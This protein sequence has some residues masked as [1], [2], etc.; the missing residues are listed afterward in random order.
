MTLT[1]KGK[2]KTSGEEKPSG[3]GTP[4]PVR[5]YKC[6][7]LGYRANECQGSKTKCFKCGKTNHKV[8]DCRSNGI[9]CYNYGE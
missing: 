4:A 5:C 6:D 2:Q 1:D 7:V 8:V 9:T 3:G